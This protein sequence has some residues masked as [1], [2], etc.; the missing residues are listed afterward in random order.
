MRL[1]RLLVL[2]FIDYCLYWKVMDVVC[3][4]KRRWDWMVVF[5]TIGLTALSCANASMGSRYLFS[6]TLALVN[7]F[8]FGWCSSRYYQV[9]ARHAI[10]MSVIFFSSLYMIDFIGVLILGIIFH[11]PSIS[12]AILVETSVWRAL[13]YGA[14]RGIEISL[15]FY[16]TR[17]KHTAIYE[18]VCKKNKT[19]CILAI[20]LFWAMSQL[21][22]VR[23]T[24][25]T[26][27]LLKEASVWVVLA[28]ALSVIFVFY[29]LYL[30][31]KLQKKEEEAKTQL[32][33]ESFQRLEVEQTNRANVIHDVKHHIH[34]VQYM[35]EENQVEE[36][37][38]HLAE[39]AGQ[40]QKESVGRWCE[41]ATVN[42]VLN[43]KIAEAKR[44]GVSMETD[45]N[46]FPCK[47]SDVEICTI[48]ANLM[49][50]AIEAATQTTTPWI[51]L[52]IY[53]DE[54]GLK[55]NIRNNYAV[56]P[57]EKDGVL[58]T[59]KT[60]KEGHGIGVENVKRIVKK[61]QGRFVYT[62]EDGTFEV[63]VVI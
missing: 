38:N 25:A 39:F 29:Q 34:T 61:N 33:L 49:D 36:A 50:N 41:N 10:V 11:M 6:N 45:I 31:I 20:A 12:D 5:V 9:K 2:Y 57:I 62:Y 47:M 1:L 52:K 21:L 44:Q 42:A 40:I 48:I 19:L 37:K 43:L 54:R 30:Q 51:C 3:E 15:C 4:K 56:E 7:A 59:T 22:V 32:L 18:V 28:I 46:V 13:Y 14:L 17:N 60:L 16:F 26:V 8:L 63:F 53:E 24:G 58:C 27:D 23:M 55:I 35:L